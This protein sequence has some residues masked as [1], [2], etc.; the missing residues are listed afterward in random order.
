MSTATISRDGTTYWIHVWQSNGNGL[1]ILVLQDTPFRADLAPPGADDCNPIIPV[2]QNFQIASNRYSRTYDIREFRVAEGGGDEV[3]RKFGRVCERDYDLKP[4]VANMSGLEIM[5]NYAEA[6]ASTGYA[7][8]N[9]HRNPDDEIYATTT[10]DGAS[11]WFHIWESNGDGL[12][13]LTLQEAPFRSSLAALTAKDCPLVPALDRFQAPNP[14][15]GKKFDAMD[16]QIVE[17]DQNK[18]VTKKGKICQQDY[19]LKHGIATMSALEIMQNYAEA[20]PA[21]GLQITNSHR[22]PDDEIFATMTKDGVESWVHVW[23]GNG[24]GLHTAVLQIEPFHSTMKAPQPGDD[25]AARQRL[26]RSLLSRIWRCRPPPPLRKQS[27]P[28]RAISP[29]CLH[30]PAPG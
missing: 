1:H 12:H 17:G 21:E 14:P 23:E 3:V 16:F 19:A 20:L 25:A 22:D 4:G 8:A 15:R 10:K 24:N 9:T 18:V 2:Q 13:I 30:C 29:I 11:T 7:I 6:T 26:R 27:I 5:R 28:Q